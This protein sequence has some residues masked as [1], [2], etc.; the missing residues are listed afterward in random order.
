MG[1]VFGGLLGEQQVNKKKKLFTCACGKLDK[2]RNLI[3]KF[4][5]FY[6]VT[7]TLFLDY[8]KAYSAKRGLN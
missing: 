4:S 1:G 5:K 2:K 6:K 8:L 7:A 3:L